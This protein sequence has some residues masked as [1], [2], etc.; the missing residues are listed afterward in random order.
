M[1]KNIKNIVFDLG[2]VLLN[3]DFPKAIE[4]F[5]KVGITNVNKRIRANEENNLFQQFEKGTISAAQFRDA[6]RKEANQPLTDEEIDALWNSM[7]LDIPRAKLELILELRGQ[8]MVYLLSNTNEIHWKLVHENSFNLNGF[9]AHDYFDEIYLSYQ[10]HL[11][12]PD[13][14]I[15]KKMMYEANILPEETFFIDDS[16][17][18]CRAA[19]ALGIHTYHYHTGEDLEVL[20]E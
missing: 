3:L 12:K 1:N 11:S 10:M 17:E 16:E 18:N 8:Y 5:E 2:G 20:F 4:A 19:E 6:I 7:L 9:R 13:P 14:E 15:F